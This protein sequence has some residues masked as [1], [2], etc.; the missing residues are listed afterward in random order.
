MIKKA[1]L[2]LI[3]LIFLSG[4]A[5]KEVIRMPATYNSCQENVIKFFVIKDQVSI[6]QIQLKNKINIILNSSDL[7]EAIKRYPQEEKEVYE[8]VELIL[9]KFPDFSPNQVVKHY[10]LLQNYCGI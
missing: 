10:K 5:S 8:S 4:C 3:I 9:K 2:L 6:N 1:F 7:K